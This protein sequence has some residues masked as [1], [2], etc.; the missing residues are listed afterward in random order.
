MSEKVKLFE[1]DL[2][3]SRHEAAALLRRLGE[4]LALDGTIHLEHDAQELSIVTSEPI[5]IEIKATHKN[6]ATR[7]EIEMTWTG[8][9]PALEPPS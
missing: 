4:R 2:S 3:L 1:S 9:A 5:T 8:G 7:L 6:D